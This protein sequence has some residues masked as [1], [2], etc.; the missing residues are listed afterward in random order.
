MLQLYRD[1]SFVGSTQWNAHA[2]DKLRLPFGR[3]DRVRAVVDRDKYRS[4]D[5]GFL[6]NRAERE[7]G[8]LYTIQSSHKS[9]VE[10]LLL[11]AA[12]VSTA[13]AIEVRTAFEPKPTAANWENK[14]GIHAWEQTLQPGAALKIH[15]GYTI[16]YPKDAAV[17]GLP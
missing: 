14:Q 4:G 6:G 7:I 12:P 11:D 2:S 5:S 10:L 17:V 3:D 16:T 1:G 8:Y 13:D 15:A 9:P